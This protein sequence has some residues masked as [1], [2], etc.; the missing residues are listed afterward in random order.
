[1][2]TI[3]YMSSTF[4]ILHVGILQSGSLWVHTVYSFTCSSS[5]YVKVSDLSDVHFGEISGPFRV[6]VRL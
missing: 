1:M 5:I 6:S 4:T 2:H 3:K